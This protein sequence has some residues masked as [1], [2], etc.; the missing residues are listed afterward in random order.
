M[1]PKSVVKVK[2]ISNDPKTRE[3]IALKGKARAIRDHTLNKRIPL[4][5]EILES[6]I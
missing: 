4:L 2:F 3:E 1:A 6:S 5:R